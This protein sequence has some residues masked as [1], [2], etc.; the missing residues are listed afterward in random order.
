MKIAINTPTGNIGRVLTEQLLGGGQDVVLMARDPEKVKPFTER[1]ATVHQGVL[2]DAA[3]VKKATVGVDVLFW[4]VPPK[5][6]ADSVRTWQNEVS[7]VGVEA[8]KTND[9]PRVVTLSS[10]GAQLPEGTGP[11]AGLHDLEKKMDASGASVMHVRADY[12]MENFFAAVGTI[13]SDGAVYLPLP[14][15]YATQMIATADIGKTVAAR[16]LDDSWTGRSVLELAGPDMVSMSQ[17]TDA[18]GKALGKDLSYVEVTDEQAL[19]AM[20]GMGVGADAAATYVEM[21]GSFRKG[22]VVHETEPEKRSISIHT[23][24][25]EIFRPAYEAMTQG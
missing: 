25:S 8:V 13:A 11:I 2:S 22:I 20:T 7:D 23:F 18:I 4:L 6:D 3:F 10:V 1:G 16:I 9:I 24:A 15:S 21:Y 17:A 5:H 12:F 14:G 19:E